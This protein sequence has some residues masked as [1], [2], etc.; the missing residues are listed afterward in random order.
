M[1]QGIVLSLFCLLLVNNAT[2]QNTRF[3]IKIDPQLSWM[4]PIGE[5]SEKA[6]NAVGLNVGLMVDK[7]FADNYAFNIGVSLNNTGGSLSYT[8]SMTWRLN[9]KNKVTV[10]DNNIVFKIKYINIPVGFKFLSKPIG[11]VKIFSEL[12]ADALVRVQALADI[13]GSSNNDAREEIRLFNLGYHIGGGVQYSL[14]GSTSIE[15]G[16]TYNNGFIDATSNKD[17]NVSIQALGARIG[18]IF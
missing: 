7:Y 13:P 10:P 11:Y 8:D 2:A 14:G 5:I 17:D 9:S 1:K 18:I 3:G 6:D 15:L 12:G 4:K 16:I